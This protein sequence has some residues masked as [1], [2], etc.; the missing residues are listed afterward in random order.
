MDSFYIWHKWSL[1]LEGVSRVIFGL[2][3]SLAH[4]GQDKLAAILQV[5]F[6]IYFLVWKWMNFD[7][8]VIEICP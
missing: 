8:D 2:S 5:A 6:E 7:S 4:W 1:S 3:Y